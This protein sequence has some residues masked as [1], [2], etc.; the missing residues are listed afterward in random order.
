MRII[1]IKHSL[2]RVLQ[3]VPCKSFFLVIV[4]FNIYAVGSCRNAG[5]NA[6]YNST[7]N[8][9]PND[10]FVSLLN[11]HFSLIFIKS[12]TKLIPLKTWILSLN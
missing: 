4:N 3:I 5:I 6:L 9:K 1:Q 12:L 7:I 8:S 2:K 10:I 11:M